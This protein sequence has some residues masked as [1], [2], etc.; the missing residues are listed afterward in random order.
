M[1]VIL[2]CSQMFSTARRMEK[3]VFISLSLPGFSSDGVQA[4]EVL[5][6]TEMEKNPEKF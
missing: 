4:V 3:Q 6:K 1:S 5:L 2:M